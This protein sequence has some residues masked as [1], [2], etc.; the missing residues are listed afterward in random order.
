VRVPDVD[1]LNAAG[2]VILLAEASALYAPYLHRR[3]DFGSDVMA[4]LD[5][6]R[7]VP[8]IDYVNAQRIRKMLLEDFHAL[9]KTID[10]LFTPATATTAPLISQKQV[11][12]DGEMQ[13]SRLA[14]TRLVRGINVLGFPALAIPCGE[15]GGLPIGLQIVGRP[16]EEDLLLMLG[17]AFPSRDH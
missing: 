16:L 17:E 2:R 4:L 5:Q 9:F 7:L 10:C 12:L 3:E 6:G 8:A 1:A 11:E 13:D 14:N 15:S